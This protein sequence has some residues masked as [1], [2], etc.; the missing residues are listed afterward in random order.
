MK[1]ASHPLYLVE[2]ANAANVTEKEFKGK[3]S[4]SR[5]CFYFKRSGTGA[6]AIYLRIEGTG[7]VG[8]HHNGNAASCP[9]VSTMS[10]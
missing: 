8:V 2:E 3:E 4:L 9:S 1:P 7:K 5:S 6:S 10:R